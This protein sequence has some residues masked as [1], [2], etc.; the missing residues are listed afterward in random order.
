MNPKK[1]TVIPISCNLLLLLNII[2]VMSTNIRTL[3]AT[4]NETNYPLKNTKRFASKQHCNA[5]ASPN[6]TLWCL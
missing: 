5:N 4:F 1:N 3:P 2:G 6:M